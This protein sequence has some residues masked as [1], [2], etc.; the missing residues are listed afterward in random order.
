MTDEAAVWVLK[1]L[2]EDT[3]NETV[4]EALKRAIDA[5][6]DKGT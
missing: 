3:F 2:L 6:E 1:A 4:K 5:L